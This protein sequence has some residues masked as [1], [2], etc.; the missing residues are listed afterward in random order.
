MKKDSAVIDLDQEDIKVGM[1]FK[2][3]DQQSTQA[4]EDR[5]ADPPAIKGPC[6]PLI[7]S[8]K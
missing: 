2:K 1:T 6:G 7:S 8:S 3:K 5:A 4:S